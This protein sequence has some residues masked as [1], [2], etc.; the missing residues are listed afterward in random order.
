MFMW[1]YQLF[2]FLSQ[3]IHL[4]KTLLISEKKP[5]NVKSKDDI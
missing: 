4:N 1:L 2:M 5:K 3:W